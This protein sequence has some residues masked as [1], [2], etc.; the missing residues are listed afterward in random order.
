ML[1]NNKFE[2]DPRESRERRS[3]KQE[4]RA[5]KQEDEIAFGKY[6]QRSNRRDKN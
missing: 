3:S 1:L 4:S 6:R 2:G 5:Q